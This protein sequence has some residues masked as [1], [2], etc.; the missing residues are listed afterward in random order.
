MRTCDTLMKKN[1][2]HLETPK[3]F[4]DKGTGHLFRRDK[5]IK[6]KFLREQGNKGNIRGS[7]SK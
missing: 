1:F 7:R 4:G 5:K 3:G 6:I 2:Q